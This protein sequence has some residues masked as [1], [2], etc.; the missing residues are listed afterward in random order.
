MKISYPNFLGIGV[1]KSGTTRLARILESHKDIYLPERKELH[2]FDDQNYKSNFYSRFKYFRNFNSNRAVGEITPSYIYDRDVPIRIYNLLG[3]D[4]KFIV[5]L[6]NPVERAYSHYCHALNNWGEQRFR[7]L[8]YPVELLS[9]KEAILSEEKRLRDGEFHPRHLSYFDKGLYSEQLRRYF[10]YFDRK[11]F[12]IYTME[13]FESSE[14]KVVDEICEFLGV[15]HNYEI[16][17]GV[18]GKNSQTRNEL[19]PELYNWLLDKY[20]GSIMDLEVLLDI[21]LSAWKKFKEC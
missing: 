8:N 19:S 4:V 7:L 5:S 16:P 3:K 2:F 13:D 9:F 21:D 12:F 1:A 20:M 6:R 11:N 14:K 18:E 17:S 10:R 15:S